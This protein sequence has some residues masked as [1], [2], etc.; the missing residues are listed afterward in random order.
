MSVLRYIVKQAIY[1]VAMHYN[2]GLAYSLSADD[3]RAVIYSGC[4]DGGPG[5]ADNWH[6]VQRT[7]DTGSDSPGSVSW[8]AVQREIQAARCR[9]LYRPRVLLGRRNHWY[10]HFNVIIYSLLHVSLIIRRIVRLQDL[11]YV[12]THSFL[13]CTAVKY[14]SGAISAKPFV[15]DRTADRSY[16]PWNR[17]NRPTL[18]KF[19]F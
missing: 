5:S 9:V 8:Q 3:V 14:V 12:A 2:A 11:G 7:A 1:E 19:I 17:P 15:F 13:S 18:V 6:Y 4:V 16:P 10:T